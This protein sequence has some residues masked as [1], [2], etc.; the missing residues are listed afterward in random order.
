MLLML[1]N[2]LRDPAGPE[3]PASLPPPELACLS[4]VFSRLD[5]LVFSV[6]HTT[7]Y[8]TGPPAAYGGTRRVTTSPQVC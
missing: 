8:M 2:I 3:G 1:K 7:Y 4:A 6:L 5:S